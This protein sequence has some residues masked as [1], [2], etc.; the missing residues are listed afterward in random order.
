ML[1]RKMNGRLV[2]SEKERKNE[3]KIRR[4]VGIMP[5]SIELRC[6]EPGC[7]FVGQTKAGLV[8][9]TRQ[10]HGSTAQFQH[11]ITFCGQSFHK[12]GIIMHMRHYSMNPNR[13]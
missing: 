11:K 1:S 2:A 10:R 3:L 8:I 5:A 12:H 7:M 9:H 6:E 4:E 13:H